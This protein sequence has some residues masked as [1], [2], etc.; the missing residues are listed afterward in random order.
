M[1]KKE[2]IRRMEEISNN[3]LPSL[4]TY[5]YDGW[6]LRSSLGFTKRANSVS[7][8]YPSSFDL[9]YKLPFCQ[10]F[11]KR[12][13]LPLIFKLFEYADPENLD[14][15]LQ[16]M[17]YIKY[18]DALV[19]SMNIKDRTFLPAEN[20]EIN[21]GVSDE[22]IDEYFKLH[23]P[24]EYRDVAFKMFEKVSDKIFS[25]QKIINKKSVAFGIGVV[26]MDYIGIFNIFVNP[27]FRR[28]GFGE[29]I[30]NTIIDIGRKEGAEEAYLQVEL[31][32]H[33]AISL[34]NKIGF[35]VLYKYWYRKKR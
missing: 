4:N 24:I 30:I 35:N 21:E 16:E 9:L 28:N 10:D 29:E 31:N 25:I 6:L 22:W 32:N 14:E 34:Y 33:P 20:I 3:A 11:Y 18:D 12:K 17:D 1:K 8:L 27:E 15:K 19:L 5:L 23:G 2:M 13:N 26:E 7:P